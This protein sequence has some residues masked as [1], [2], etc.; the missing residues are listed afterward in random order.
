M[1]LVLQHYQPD[2]S[3]RWDQFVKQHPQ[4]SPFHLTAWKHAIEDTFRYHSHYLAAVDSGGAVHGVLPLFLVSNAL[5]GKALIST[6]FAVYGGIL[7]TSE[8]ARDLLRDAAAALGRSQEVEYVELRNAWPEQYAGFA[9]VLRYVTFTQE[10]SPDAE[11]ILESIPRK[12]RY[13]VRKALKHSY[14]ARRTSDIG[15][16][17][18]LYS[19][20]LQRLG[21]PCFLKK[22]FLNLQKYFQDDVEVRE[23]VLDGKV[24]AAVMSFFFRDQLLPY[25][26]AADPALNAFAPSNY[27]YYELMEWGGKNGFRLFDFGRSKVESGSFDFKAHWGMQTRQLPYEMLLLKR[28]ELP[29][30]TPK[31]P[32]FQFAI[33]V[34]Q[35]L[36]LPVTRLLGP[37]LIRLVP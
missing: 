2:L 24:V 9:P 14:L 4:G 3:E 5:I 22:H 6:P 28:Q 16:F 8:E 29:D 11:A 7:S 12:T 30:F 13:M 23:V 35:R 18:D 17:F 26:G 20:N 36:P 19:R 25:Y 1:P 10:I 31:N 27:M 15:A 21:T 37:A 32:R 34:W 33:R